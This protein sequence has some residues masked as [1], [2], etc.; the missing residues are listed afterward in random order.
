MSL[1]SALS[2]IIHV[3]RCVI[4]DSTYD[5]V[6]RRVPR[7]I[8]VHEVAIE[9]HH[10]DTVVLFLKKRMCACNLCD[11]S[12]KNYCNMLKGLTTKCRTSSGTFL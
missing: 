6:Q 3:L 12:G 11:S 7:R 2:E 8:A 9:V 10:N 4:D 5:I 1:R